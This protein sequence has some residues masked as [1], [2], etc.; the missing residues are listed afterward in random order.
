MTVF[1]IPLKPCCGEVFL[2]EECDCAVIA[3]EAAAAWRQPI[4]V[5]STAPRQESPC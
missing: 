5:R 4:I 3:A 1:E 2:G